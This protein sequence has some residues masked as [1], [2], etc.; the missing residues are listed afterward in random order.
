MGLHVFVQEIAP[1]VVAA[2]VDVHLATHL[3]AMAHR[4]E[5]DVAILVNGAP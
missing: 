5:Y 3:V 1:S 2:C 4:D